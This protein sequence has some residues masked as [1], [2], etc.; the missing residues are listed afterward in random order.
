MERKEIVLQDAQKLG[1][2]NQFT[3]YRRSTKKLGKNNI[4][5]RTKGYLNYND[6]IAM[7]TECPSVS[8]VTPRISDW[9]RHPN[10]S[11]GRC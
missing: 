6:V 2:A 8:A 1:G 11:S 4:Q 9:E 5:F 10:P 7:E 3:L